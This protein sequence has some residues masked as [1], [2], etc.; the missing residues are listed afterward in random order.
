MTQDETIV[1]LQT[2]TVMWPASKINPD[3]L[4]VG[5]WHEMLKEYSAELVGVAIRSL[6]ATLKFPPSIA[7][8]CGE[9][10]RLTMEASGTAS[11]G[12]AWA[13][14]RRAI[15]WYGYSRGEDAR[16]ALGEEIWKAVEMV[17]GWR[18]LCLGEAEP[19][20]L[21]AQFERRY[22]AMLGQKARTVQLPEGVREEMARLVGP[23][24][25]RLA[26]GGGE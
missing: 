14:V 23:L 12:E 9:I 24:T 13:K 7:D 3:P 18:D 4:T 25:E 11:A 17:G 19:A 15:R 22:N 10:S 26:I 20:V 2:I 21:S 6:G 1:M 16:A 8:V 5:I